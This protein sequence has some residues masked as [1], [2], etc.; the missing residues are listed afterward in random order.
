MV[1]LKLP[2]TRKIRDGHTSRMA[3]SGEGCATLSEVRNSDFPVAKRSGYGQLPHNKRFSDEA[4]K[5]VRD[6]I[7]VMKM[8]FGKRLVFGTLTLPGSTDKARK[9]IATWSGAFLQKITKWVERHCPGTLWC[10]VW[11]HQRNGALH[12]H[13]VMGNPDILRLRFLENNWKLFVN[14]MFAYAS[15]HLEI[16]FFERA[17][18]GT[19]YGYQKITRNSCKPVYKCV[20]RYMSKYLVKHDLP[21]GVYSPS[22]YWGCSDA[23]KVAARDATKIVCMVT[24]DIEMA[25]QVFRKL[26]STISQ[27]SERYYAW[28]SRYDSGSAGVAC[29]DDSPTGLLVFNR[30]RT[31]LKTL[32]DL[33]FHG[34]VNQDSLAA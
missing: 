25:V 1:R 27:R 34:V 23:L 29:Y 30:L 26:Q 8:M 19:W 2:T 7:G 16:D 5:Q 28:R 9:A 31:E 33:Y 20:K 6:V 18:G 4:K 15:R 11:E 12:L 10:S 17:C 13:V 14:K 32:A 24:P 21:A 22:Q 3:A